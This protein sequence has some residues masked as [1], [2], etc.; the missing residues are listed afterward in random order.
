MSR[1]ELENDIAFARV[2]LAMP[3]EEFMQQTPREWA[4]IV[5]RLWQK[6]PKA[7]RDLI[8]HPD[9]QHPDE[10]MRVLGSMGG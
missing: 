9:E 8:P 3:R 6:V 4:N 5:H 1:T 7:Q 10:M 2:E